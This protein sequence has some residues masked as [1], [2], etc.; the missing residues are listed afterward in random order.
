MADYLDDVCKE[1]KYKTIHKEIRSELQS[2]IDEFVNQYGEIYGDSARDIAGRS[3]GNAKELGRMINKQY[4]MPFNSSLGLV[5]WAAVNTMLGWALYPFWISIWKYHPTIVTPVALIALLYC[6]INMFY[7]RRTHFKFSMRDWGQIALG[8]VIGSAVSITALLLISNIGV[9]GNYIYGVRCPIPYKWRPWEYEMP[10][11]LFF[12]W[13]LWMI[14]MFSLGKPK[15][16][17]TF[18][19]MPSKGKTALTIVPY[20]GNISLGDM[21]QNITDNDSI[22]IYG[23]KVSRGKIIGDN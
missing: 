16:E 20:G 9:F 14:Y 15:G 6:I 1:I 3:M 11:V 13:A 19:I 5:I 2:H 17:K 12:F 18:W 4:R 8:T 23:N 7:L 10:I 21:G 22:D